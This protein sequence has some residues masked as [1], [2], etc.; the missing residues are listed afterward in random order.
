MARSTTVPWKNILMS[1][2]GDFIPAAVSAPLALHSLCCRIRLQLNLRGLSSGSVPVTTHRTPRRAS[3]PRRPSGTDR[4]RQSRPPHGPSHSLSNRAVNH[5]PNLAEGRGSGAMRPRTTC[6]TCVLG[7]G[8]GLQAPHM[9]AAGHA[10][11]ALPRSCRAFHVLGIETLDDEHR[12][13]SRC[14]DGIRGLLPVFD[15]Q[16]APHTRRAQRR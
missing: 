10:H 7:S 8:T 13:A 3:R 15:E 6:G 4:L 1:A 5:G 2:T 12:Y 11:N 16:H 14:P 9:L